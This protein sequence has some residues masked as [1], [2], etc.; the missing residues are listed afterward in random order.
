MLSNRLPDK[1]DPRVTRTRAL[2]V[3]AFM[4]LLPDRGFQSLTVQAITERASINRATFYAHFP[5]K[6]A[7]LDFSI[8]Q[9]FRQEIEK[10][11]LDACHYSA[12]N[13]RALILVVCDFVS[14]AHAQCAS[15]DGRFESLVE[16]QVKR[17]LQE[18]LQAW[19]E[20]AGSA[21]DP[22]TAATAASWAIYGLVIQ[23]SHET[24]KQK[25]S[26]EQFATQTLPLIVA[27][28]TVAPAI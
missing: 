19:L 8:R 24:S 5:D 21:V 13:L 28:L 10:R 11:T 23:W 18:L 7:L 17:H 25:P 15:S 2:I 4:E 16:T 3:Q 26:A 22:Q 1:E 12:D 6:Y 14:K 9:A 27:N 20:E